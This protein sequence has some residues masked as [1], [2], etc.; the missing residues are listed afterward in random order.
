MGGKNEHTAD[1]LQER[2]GTHHRSKDDLIEGLDRVLLRRLSGSAG[3]KLI[4][5]DSDLGLHKG[6]RQVRACIE[7]FHRQTYLGQRAELLLELL[8]DIKVVAFAQIAVL[9]RVTR[10]PKDDLEKSSDIGAGVRKR[11]SEAKKLSI[12]VK[13]SNKGG[14]TQT[15]FPEGPCRPRHKLWMSCARRCL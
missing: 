3:E 9:K 14:A 7:S 5:V 4:D 6:G 2:L 10:R 11:M 13:L 1:V 15:S 12:S 8:N